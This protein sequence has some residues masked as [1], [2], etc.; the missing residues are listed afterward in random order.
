MSRLLIRLHL[1]AVFWP[2]TRVFVSSN[3]RVFSFVVSG[4]GIVRKGFPVRLVR[5]DSATVCSSV[6]V[7]SILN[8]DLYPLEAYS[9]TWCQSRIQ[10][11][12]SSVV[13]LSLDAGC[14]H[15]LQSFFHLV[16]RFLCVSPVDV[17]ETAPECLSMIQVVV[18]GAIMFNFGVHVVNASL[19]NA[20]GLAC[21]S[22]VLWPRRTPWL[23]F[24][25][26]R[27]RL[28]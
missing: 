12:P 9:H 5:K 17:C 15:L 10:Q 22:C 8:L 6:C 2:C 21:R 23:V 7:V 1:N 24:S 27:D 16:I 18:D 28:S 3:L 25:D 14:L 4:F 26:K 19:Q 20:A 13:F 11:M